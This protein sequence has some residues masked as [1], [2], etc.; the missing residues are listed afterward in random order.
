MRVISAVTTHPNTPETDMI[1][2]I[3]H[4]VKYEIDGEICTIEIKATDPIN[5][6]DIIRQYYEQ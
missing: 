1:E 3:D 4:T 5:A 2:Q 6:I